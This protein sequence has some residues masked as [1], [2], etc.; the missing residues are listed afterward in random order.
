MAPKGTQSLE[1]LPRNGRRPCRHGKECRRQACNYSHEATSLLRLL[2]WLGSAKHSLDVC[3][4]T[5]TC[6]ELAD[7]LLAAHSGRRAG[8]RAWGCPMGGAWGFRSGAGGHGS[9]GVAGGLRGSGR[10]GGATPGK[11][12]WASSALITR[13]GPHAP[14]R[15]MPP[16]T[17]VLGGSHHVLRPP[18]PPSPG[19]C[20]HP[21]RGVRVR[22]ISDNDQVESQGERP[23]G[24]C[25]ALEPRPA[26][27]AL[28][29]PAR[30]HHSQ[31]STLPLSSRP[32]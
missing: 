27:A 30:L 17:L 9:R 1:P 12:A 16:S 25:A 10:A 21:D 2:Q 4:F 19:R 32:H 31:S 6:D 18:P 11:G 22:I 7:A 20:H 14:L 29:V 28:A 23:A 26:A 8:A 24:G 13:P 5:I 3:V 15:G